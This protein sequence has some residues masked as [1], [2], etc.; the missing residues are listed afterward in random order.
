VRSVFSEL[1]SVAAALA[2]PVGIVGVFPFGAFSFQ[3]TAAGKCLARAS[4]VRLTAENERL[5]LRAVR[6]S[7]QEKGGGARRL[8][9]DL[10]CAELP[11]DGRMSVLSIR[12]RSRPPAPPMALC[13]RTPFLPSQRAAPPLPIKVENVAEPPTFSREELL[14]MN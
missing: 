7:W 14:K 9:A 4:F 1:L 6:T 2:I 5:A 10:L 13:G 11:E 3:A 12:D 8:R